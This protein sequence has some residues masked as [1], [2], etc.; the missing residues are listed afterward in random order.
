MLICSQMTLHWKLSFVTRLILIFFFFSVDVLGISKVSEQ[1]EATVSEKK[2]DRMVAIGM[3][4]M[5]L[6]RIW[7]ILCRIWRNLSRRPDR[8]LNLRYFSSQVQDTE[9]LN[10]VDGLQVILHTASIESSF[11]AGI[12]ELQIRPSNCS[13]NLK[14]EQRLQ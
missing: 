6:R 11:E 12:L 4:M 10:P 9:K 13:R 1:K 14:M 3:K 8:S 2:S 7:L 5:I